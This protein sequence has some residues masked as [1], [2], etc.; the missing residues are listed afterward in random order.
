M[1]KQMPKVY[2]VNLSHNPFASSVIP[3]N[4]DSGFEDISRLIL[5]N[6]KVSW[7]TVNRLLKLMPQ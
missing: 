4:F 7:E 3:D 1:L 5:N 2:F 6:T